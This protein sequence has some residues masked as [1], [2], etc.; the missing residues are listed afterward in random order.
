MQMPISSEDCELLLEFSKAESLA[1][2]AKA[3]GRDISVVSRKL[4]RLAATVPVLEKQQS[5]WVITPLGKE[6]VQWTRDAVVSQ[7]RL[8]ERPHSLRIA[9]T[10]EFAARVLAPALPQLSKK[11]PKIEFEIYSFEEGTE[12]ALL[13][14]N[15]DFA[16]DCGR[17]TNPDIRFRLLA[18]EEVGLVASPAFLRAH[19]ITKA[20]NLFQA[21]HLEFLRLK[22]TR[23]L[24]LHAQ[25]EN[26]VARFNDIGACRSAAVAGAGWTLL[27]V[28]AVREELQQ[29][30]LKRLEFFTVEQENFGLWWLRD[31]ISLKPYL[32][33]F[34]EWLKNAQL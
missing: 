24:K 23:Y 12:E 18:R 13:Q 14:G 6:I 17:P 19:P 5:R 34:A 30:K 8:L 10:R 2:L 28:Y 4:Q 25:V 22:P 26:R 21:P 32:D 16:F 29:G 27:P 1:A 20:E 3:V 9:T 7:S 31:R 15:I 33:I 11:L